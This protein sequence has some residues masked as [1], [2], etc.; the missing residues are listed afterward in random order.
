L[1]E[2]ETETSREHSHNI[3]LFPFVKKEQRYKHT[4]IQAE[5]SRSV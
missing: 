5:D 3:R 4:C 2:D 1:Q